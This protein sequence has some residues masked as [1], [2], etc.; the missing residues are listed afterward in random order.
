MIARGPLPPLGKIDGKP[1][2]DPKHPEK[3]PGPMPQSNRYKYYF[4]TPD[5]GFLFHSVYGSD[6]K[7]VPPELSV[8]VKAKNGFGKFIRIKNY[9][10]SDPAPSVTFNAL[11]GRKKNGQLEVYAIEKNGNLLPIGATSSEGVQSWLS[12]SNKPLWYGWARS[13]FVIIEVQGRTVVKKSYHTTALGGLT[14]GMLLRKGE[15]FAIVQPA[16]EVVRFRLTPTGT[17]SVLARGKAPKGNLWP[18]EAP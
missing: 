8:A 14:E 17:I 12:D 4:T 2:F 18:A 9:G 10:V 1:F 13:K 11:A 3:T 7:N 16:G 15:F 6:Y 5:G